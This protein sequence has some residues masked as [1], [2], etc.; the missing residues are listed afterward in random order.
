MNSHSSSS[1]GG[2]PALACYAVTTMTKGFALLTWPART[3]EL[4]ELLARKLS[5]A[6]IDNPTYPNPFCVLEPSGKSRCHFLS[7]K[8]VA[9]EPVAQMNLNHERDSVIDTTLAGHNIQVLAA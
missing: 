9:V 8:R 1:L 7:G 4:A 5:A 2:T 6:A 3:I